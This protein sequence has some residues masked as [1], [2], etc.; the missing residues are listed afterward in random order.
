MSTYMMEGYDAIVLC[1]IRICFY[2]IEDMAVGQLLAGRKVDDRRTQARWPPWLSQNHQSCHSS[3]E[4]A[5][6]RSRRHTLALVDEV[7]APMPP[8]ARNGTGERPSTSLSSRY[9]TAWRS[10]RRE[11]ACRRN[12]LQQVLGL[13]RLPGSN[14]NA[15]VPS[16]VARVL[17]DPRHASIAGIEAPLARHTEPRR[18]R[19]GS[20]SGPE[21]SVGLELTAGSRHPC[22]ALCTSSTFLFH[23][24]SGP[25]LDNLA[26]T[27]A[28]DSPSL[29]EDDGRG[30][31]SD[32]T[33]GQRAKCGNLD[34]LPVH[35]PRFWP[36]RP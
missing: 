23:H 25:I 36:S 11:A 7:E 9:W 15:A 19:K 18:A 16:L 34:H 1:R 32:G 22:P 33:A 2:C 10:W 20:C 31:I 17:L 35:P 6:Q 30:P 29:C 21:P 12:V 28:R 8:V 27:R 5:S 13:L 3:Y 4:A 24:C 14:G 26:L